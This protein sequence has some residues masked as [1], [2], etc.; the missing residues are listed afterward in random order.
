MIRVFPR[1][2]KWT[3]TDE[4]A[5]IGDPPLFR[6]KE[7]PV[8]ISIT[9]TWDIPE[10]K[11]LYESWKK[12][13]QDVQI[14][15][16]AFDDRGDN[17][18]P[19]LF[20]KPGV[21]ITSRGCPRRCPWC[22]VPKREGTIRELPICDGWIIQDNNLLACS[23]E[24]IEATMTMLRRQKRAAIF[25]GGLD[26]RLFNDWHRKLLDSI[27][28]HELWFSCDHPNHFSLLKQTAKIL[29]GIPTS[30]W[31]A[32]VMIGYDG[33][34]I[35]VAEKRLSQVY[36]LGFL[37]FAQLYQGKNKIIY[38]KEW[39]NLNRKWSRPAAYKAKKK[40]VVV[41]DVLIGRPSK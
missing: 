17:F 35:S 27:R 22:F 1:Q 10:G 8:R 21:T 32:Y 23:D 24:H 31:R 6:P 15:G 29:D 30:K 4:L 11:R 9:F 13:Y 19:G 26:P 14:G 2:T 39:R 16:P 38:N 18:I 7:Q 36:E 5:F 37:P 20:L 28:F 40:A 25:S 33:E 34:S 41:Q 12:Y 3:P